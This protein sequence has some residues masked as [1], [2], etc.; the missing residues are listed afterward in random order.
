MNS[1]E[2]CTVSFGWSK[3]F[4]WW[5]EGYKEG[6]SPEYCNKGERW[7]RPLDPDFLPWFISRDYIFNILH[8]VYE[9]LGLTRACAFGIKYAGRSAVDS[10]YEWWHSH[11]TLWVKRKKILWVQ[12][13]LLHEL[14]VPVW[15][16]DVVSLN[17]FDRKENF[18]RSEFLLCVNDCLHSIYYYLEPWHFTLASLKIYVYIIVV[19]HKNGHKSFSSMWSC[20]LPCPHAPCHD[21]GL[22]VWVAP[23]SGTW[24]NIMCTEE[25]FLHVKSTSPYSLVSLAALTPQLPCEQVQASL[26]DYESCRAQ[27][28]NHH[29]HWHHQTIVCYGSHSRPWTFLPAYQRIRRKST[30]NQNSE[31]R[32]K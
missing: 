8:Y 31:G 19:E 30:S 21:P 29:L 12:S 3:F 5:S 18:T 2:T 10:S 15:R 6:V 27:P 9:L 4:T 11:K 1:C 7:R 22:F 16:S 23:A 28:N 24:E 20:F 14:A 25:F 13:L 26:L 32:T 17:L